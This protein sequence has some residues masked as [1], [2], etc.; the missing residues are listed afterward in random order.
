MTYKQLIER[1]IEFGKIAKMDDE[2]TEEKFRDLYTAWVEYLEVGDYLEYRNNKRQSK[3]KCPYCNTPYPY[4]GS[5]KWPE[6]LRLVMCDG[7]AKTFIVDK[8]VFESYISVPLPDGVRKI[9]R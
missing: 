1:C 9:I 3:I 8:Q 5:G 4:A 7:C 2:Y 6:G